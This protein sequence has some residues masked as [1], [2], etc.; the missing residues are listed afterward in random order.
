MTKFNKILKSP[1]KEV[2]A[3]KGTLAKLY[4][5]VWA[6]RFPKTGE[7]TAVEV[8][9][10]LMLKWL[11]DPANCKF[12]DAKYKSYT[13]QN[14]VNALAGEHMSWRTFLN[15][16]ILLRPMHFKLSIECKWT[17]SNTTIT[18]VSVNLDEKEDRT[19]L[20]MEWDLEGLEGEDDTDEGL[21]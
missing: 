11:D 19:W 7:D 21:L 12:N 14:F 5:L 2:A 16:I 10:H 13:R 1:T 18:S 8:L 3:A 6:D 17:E 9:H 4:R 20:D 15:G